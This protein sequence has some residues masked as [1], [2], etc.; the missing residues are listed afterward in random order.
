MTSQVIALTISMIHLAE[1]ERGVVPYDLKG[2]L[3]ITRAFVDDVNRINR[4]HNNPRRF[5]LS[6]RMNL[7]ASK[8]MAAIWLIYYGVK[9][10]KA[11]G[12]PMN[13]YDLCMLYNKG[14]AGYMRG[15]G[16]SY[17][18]MIRGKVALLPKADSLRK[19]LRI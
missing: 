10:E 13:E 16:A 6:E 14:Y 1:T 18:S 2:E 17:L 4:M 8:E 5:L 7:K 9:A 3:Q 12:R 11:T 19:A 15:E